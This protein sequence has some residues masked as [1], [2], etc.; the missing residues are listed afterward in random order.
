MMKIS[1]TLNGQEREVTV[2]ADKAFVDVLRED[3]A[4]TGTKVGCGEGECGTCTI[5][6]DD[7]AVCS[8][9]LLA[10]QVEGHRVTTIEGLTED[11]GSPGPV[12]QAFIE[13]GAVQCG[14]CTP[15][16]VVAGE[17]LLRSN[18]SANRQDIVTAL[19][20]NLCRCT[21]YEKIFEAIERLTK[22][23]P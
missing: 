22:E 6:L 8:C 14:F 23:Q 3:L 5:L 13:T 11:D 21:G 12:Q 18:P 7:D 10:G 15:G 20:G 2:P 17:A 4:L 16:M 1:F 9:L 19:A